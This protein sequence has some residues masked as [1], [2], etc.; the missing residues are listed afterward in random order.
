MSAEPAPDADARDGIIR[1]E[2]ALDRD[3]RAIFEAEWV[4]GAVRM[5]AAAWAQMPGHDAVE[6]SGRPRKVE[7]VL[8][9]ADELAAA[10]AAAKLGRNA[11]H[12]EVT[13]ARE[14]R[15]K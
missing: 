2:L 12:R 8:A 15:S 1:V 13:K 7:A 3:G 14:R 10:V 4:L 11:R 6:I 5:G 9:F